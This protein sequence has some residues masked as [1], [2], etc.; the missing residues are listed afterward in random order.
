MSK[1]D[2]VPEINPQIFDES[3]KCDSCGDIISSDDVKEHQGHVICSGCYYCKVD[4]NDNDYQYH[5]VDR[6]EFV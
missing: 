2:A 1:T 5:G 3:F 4:C 6:G